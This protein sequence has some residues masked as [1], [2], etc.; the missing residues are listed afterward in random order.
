[1]LAIECGK[2]GEIDLTAFYCQHLSRITRGSLFDACAYIVQCNIAVPHRFQPPGN[3]CLC[4]WTNDGDGSLVVVAGRF[5]VQGD[6]ERCFQRAM[7]IY[8]RLDSLDI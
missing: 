1:M 7:L 4:P 6:I 8:K 5:S 2:I 3:A